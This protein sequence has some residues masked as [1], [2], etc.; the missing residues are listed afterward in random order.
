MIFNLECI[1]CIR[2]YKDMIHILSLI[3]LDYKIILQCIFN[4]FQCTDVREVNLVYP[5]HNGSWHKQQMIN[6]DKLINHGKP[7]LQLWID[8]LNEMFL[9][10]WTAHE[11]W[12]ITFILLKTRRA[13]GHQFVNLLPDRR[14]QFVIIQWNT[15]VVPKLANLLI[16]SQCALSE[17]ISSSRK[18][19][20]L[21]VCRFI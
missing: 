1:I 18:N 20:K 17:P 15:C 8:S 7:Q 10:K 6:Y 16:H 13:E 19:R 9:T 21:T 3:I 14:A 11:Q 2:N 12:N 5:I 4:C